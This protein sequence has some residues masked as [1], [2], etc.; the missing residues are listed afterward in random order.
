MKHCTWLSSQTS[1]SLILKPHWP[2]RNTFVDSIG[3][4][5]CFLLN[6][7]VCVFAAAVLL[8]LLPHCHWQAVSEIQVVTHSSSH[9]ES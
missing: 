1:S 6:L 3:P 4:F 2:P 9:G 8:L 7:S 5:S